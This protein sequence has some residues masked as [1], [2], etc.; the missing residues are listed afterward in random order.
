MG[1]MG[2]GYFFVVEGYVVIEIVV[3]LDASHFIMFFNNF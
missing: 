2:L 3:Y 1:G